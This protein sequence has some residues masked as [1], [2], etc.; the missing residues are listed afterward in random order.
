MIGELV[1][2]A[3][4]GM[5]PLHRSGLKRPTSSFAFAELVFEATFA[6]EIH[7]IRFVYFRAC[8]RQSHQISASRAHDARNSGMRRL[9]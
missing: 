4:W 7:Y 2:V 6:I 1:V 8:L 3:A 5:R 9:R